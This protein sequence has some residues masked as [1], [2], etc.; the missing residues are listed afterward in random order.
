MLSNLIG[1]EIDMNNPDDQWYHNTY[2][3]TNIFIS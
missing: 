3:Y 2:K 1:D